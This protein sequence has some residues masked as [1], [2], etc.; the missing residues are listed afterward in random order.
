MIAEYFLRG[1]LVGLVFGV[2]LSKII[3]LRLRISAALS[4]RCVQ[5]MSAAV[6]FFQAIDENKIMKTAY[7]FRRL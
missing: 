2:G 5:R 4:F 3:R 6:S 1:L 7:D